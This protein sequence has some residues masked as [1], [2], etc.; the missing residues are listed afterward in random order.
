MFESGPRLPRVR[1]STEK[2]KLAFCGDIMPGAEV[3]EH[4]GRASLATWLS[5]VSPAW[6][7]ADALI[8]NL[9]SPCVVEARP[10]PKS[11]P[12][13]SLWSPASRV[14]ELAEAGFSAVTLA[15]NHVLD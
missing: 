2:V 12:E 15:N 5:G 9:E 11:Q 14:R 7:D 1:R 8:G 13:L 10:V 4:V 6:R 3:G